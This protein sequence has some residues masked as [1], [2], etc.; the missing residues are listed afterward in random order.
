MKTKILLCAFLAVPFLSAQTTLVGK[1]SVAGGAA[2]ADTVV[3]INR[4][5]DVA[6]PS[7]GPRLISGAVSATLSVDSSGQFR[8]DSLP[9]G[10]YYICA[11]NGRPG[12]ISNCEWTVPK[13]VTISGAASVVP[14]TVALT[15]GSIVTINVADPTGVMGQ[16]HRIRLG[17]MTDKGYYVQAKPAGSGG[18]GQ[19]VVTIPSL[20]T[21]RLFVDSDLTVADAAGSVLQTRQP[22]SL[23]ITGESDTTVSLSVR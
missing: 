12:F 18:N 9:S 21:V 16:G 5:P 13:P 10:R 2:P 19:Y 1:V 14:C 17:V 4:I 7:V 11:Y 6:T 22:S 8:S 3:T 20:A 15:M 23:V